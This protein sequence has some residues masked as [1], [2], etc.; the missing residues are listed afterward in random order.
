MHR[1]NVSFAAFPFFLEEALRGKGASQRYTQL[2][3]SCSKHKLLE[4]SFCS[5]RFE[6]R[7]NAALYWGRASFFPRQ[8]MFIAQKRNKKLLMFNLKREWN[9]TILNHDDI[10]K[11]SSCY[12]VIYYLQHRSSCRE[13][14]NLLNSLSS[15]L[16]LTWS[17]KKLIFKILLL[18]MP[19]EK[20]TQHHCWCLHIFL[21]AST[22]SLNMDEKKVCEQ[23][24]GGKNSLRVQ[25]DAEFLPRR[26]NKQRY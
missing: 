1:F 7:L 16:S 20:S 26:K 19:L 22:S 13:F 12:E 8:L 14:C 23:K 25:A 17:H 2:I 6:L 4:W 11:R 21:S 18:F 5:R 3:W 10:K 15:L 9:C 24:R